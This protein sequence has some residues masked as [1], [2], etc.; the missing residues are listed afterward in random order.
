MGVFTPCLFRISVMKMILANAPHLG[1][2]YI[3][4]S[5]HMFS[6]LKTTTFTKYLFI[7]KMG[8]MSI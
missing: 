7:N 6:A 2:S 4:V 3:T 5:V 1:K 8:K